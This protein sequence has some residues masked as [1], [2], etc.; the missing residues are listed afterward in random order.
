M[1]QAGWPL[2][3]CAP[4][5]IR[6]LQRKRTGGGGIYFK[7]LVH[8]TEETSKFAGQASRGDPGCLETCI[9]SAGL[10]VTVIQNDLHRSLW[11]N[12]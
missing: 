10:D 8:M 11:N 3:S 1:A 12:V 6:F 9:Q 2:R 5:C 7:D 4:D